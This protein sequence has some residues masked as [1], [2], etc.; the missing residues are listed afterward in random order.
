RRTAR[1]RPGDCAEDHQLPTAARAVH[2]GR[3]ARCDSRHRPGA[4]RESR[5]AGGAVNR[6]LPAH[7]A[8][9]A[10]VAGLA[11]SNAIRIG[12]VAALVAVALAA[13]VAACAEEDARAPLAGLALV[14]AW[15]WGSARL[16]ALDRSTL[17]ADVGRAGRFLVVVT[18]E[19]R[20]GAF[21]Q[22]LAA[23][24]RSFER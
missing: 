20:R 2:V 22:R 14:L 15:G 18:G 21:A 8:V 7:V 23:R 17:R 9:A 10:A 6:L 16:D 12:I 11:L 19:P 1:D 24:A 4:A 13:F 3:G 5:G